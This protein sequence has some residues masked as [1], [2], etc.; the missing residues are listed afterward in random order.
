MRDGCLWA[1]SQLIES[2]G[3]V[4]S[5]VK[6]GHDVQARGTNKPTDVDAN[7]DLNALSSLQA[8]DDDDDEDPVIKERRFRRECIERAQAL[9][10]A[11]KRVLKAGF[12]HDLKD[13]VVTST[14]PFQVRGVC[15]V[16]QHE[17]M[18]ERDARSAVG[19]RC[20]GEL[21]AAQGRRVAP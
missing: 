4:S 16:D 17:R 18:V 3:A 8:K 7:A 1:V 9:P 19:R 13:V 6:K 15:I 21:L 11:T 2:D 14:V 5:P 12:A 20:R 10:L